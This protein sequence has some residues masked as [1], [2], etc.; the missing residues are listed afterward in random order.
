M[1]LLP[2]ETGSSIPLRQ[3]ERLMSLEWAFFVPFSLNLIW[4]FIWYCIANATHRFAK[5]TVNWGYC[6]IDLR[7]NTVGY[8]APWISS[9]A[10]DCIS[11]W[12]D[13]ICIVYLW[14]IQSLLDLEE[15]GWIKIVNILFLALDRSICEGRDDLKY[16]SI[17]WCVWSI[18]VIPHQKPR[19]V[20]LIR[21]IKLNLYWIRKSMMKHQQN[22]TSLDLVMVVRS[23]CFWIS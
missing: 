22:W 13:M 2:C 17:F 1:S 14:N 16:E 4:W 7:L 6:W 9:C 15:W 19:Y 3:S 10:E 21:F 23:A 5:V 18:F 12:N 8:S 11:Q 20:G